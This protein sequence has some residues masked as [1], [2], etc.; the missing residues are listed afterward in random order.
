METLIMR[1]KANS[2]DGAYDDSDPND[3]P[4]SCHRIAG[5]VI[6]ED[7]RSSYKMKGMQA[8]ET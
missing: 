3:E 7:V 2:D 5:R 6:D 4:Q 8:K 1:I